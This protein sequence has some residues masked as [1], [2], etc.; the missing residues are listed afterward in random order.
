MQITTEKTAPTSTTLTV[1]VS[2]SDMAATKQRIEQ[3]LAAK[4][5]LPGFREGKV[6]PELAAKEINEQSLYEAFLS[7]FVPQAAFQALET[8]GIRPVLPPEVSVTKFVPFQTLEITIKADHL[9]E[10]SLA[11]YKN[12]AETM[13]AVKVTAA[14][15]NQIL[16]RVRLD[17]A[18][19]TEVDR[20]AA[21]TDRVWLDFE[22]FDGQGEAVPGAA[23]KD[24]PLLLGSRT[25]IPGFEDKL[26][27]A[28]KGQN[29][30]FKLRFP[31]DYGAA[32]MAG[33]EVEFKVVVNRVEKVELPELNDALAAKTGVAKTLA[34]LK[35]FIRKQITADKR[36]QAESVM[37]G[38]IVAKL[39]ERSSVEIPESLIKL[40]LD[41]LNGE[42]AAFLKD[43]GLE[44]EAWLKSAKL[45]A[46]EHTERLKQTALNRIKGGV[47]LREFA[48]A[49]KI[50]VDPAA[51]EADFSRRSGEG[52]LSPKQ[53]A[54]LKADIRAQLLTRQALE[55]LT[56]LVLKR[57]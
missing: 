41:K 48:R 22:G 10:I 11:D 8:K 30:E 49:E 56:K 35:Q 36:R 19:Y 38:R 20:P 29:L 2:A 26:V 46:E 33:R 52:E 25:F 47:V 51:I 13:P 6:P 14:E 40:E 32:A 57:G 23:S 15:V 16:E 18:D 7:D 45:S 17:F 21:E 3:Q 37:Q 55:K 4:V 5:K 39:A 53:A 42:H 12:L 27:G 50:E 54:D 9:G 44:L 34:E 24:Y 43:S 28:K 1:D 31:S